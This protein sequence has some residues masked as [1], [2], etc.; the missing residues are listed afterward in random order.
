MS[1]FEKYIK[2]KNKYINLKANKMIGGAEKVSNYYLHVRFDKNIEDKIKIVKEYLYDA[3]YLRESLLLN[4][5]GEIIK[6]NMPSHITLAYGPKIKYDND[7]DISTL[8]NL[9]IK[10]K[11]EI[12]NIYPDFVKKFKKMKPIIIYKGVT[13]FLRADKIVLKMEIESE[14]LKKAVLFLRKNTK[15]FDEIIEE[16]KIS[17]E[18]KREQIK[19]RFPVL[20]TEDESFDKKNP[21][22]FLH[23][24]L[25]SLKSDVN[26][27]IIIQAIKEA[28][29]KLE[30]YGFKKDTEIK[31]D[32][33]DIKT[34]I[35][36]RFIELFKI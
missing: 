20:F 27:D 17:Y 35:T 36:K 26:E 12:N 33:I 30:E 24:T 29:N 3:S 9:E 7:S 15:D 6:E 8:E 22:G 23:I 11:K 1:Y 25:I 31:G 13:P 19:N 10:S 5:K 32:Y 34:P 4:Q 28:E 18:K 21:K 14:E 2:Y 16:W